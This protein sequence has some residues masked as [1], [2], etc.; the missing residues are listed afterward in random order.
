MEIGVKSTFKALDDNYLFGVSSVFH[1][2][3]VDALEVLTLH[4]TPICVFVSSL[5]KSWTDGKAHAESNI[6]QSVNTS[7]HR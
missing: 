6:A 1:R 7:V 2:G 3:F 4:I 5:P